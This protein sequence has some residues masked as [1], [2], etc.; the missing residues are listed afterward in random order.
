VG[1]TKDRPKYQSVSLTIPFVME[2]K[3]HI[4]NRIEYRSIAEF[5]RDSAREKMLAEKEWGSD[6]QT[7]SFSVPFIKEIK[8]S[9]KDSGGCYDNVDDWIRSAMRDKLNWDT[10]PTFKME[11]ERFKSLDKM[12]ASMEKIEKKW[13]GLT[14]DLDWGL[15]DIEKKTMYKKHFLK[16]QGEIKK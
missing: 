15:T 16:H 13:E 7:V 12:I 1:K 5:V 2:I 10:S 9:I 3:E 8:K 11:K 6:V 14:A 4:K